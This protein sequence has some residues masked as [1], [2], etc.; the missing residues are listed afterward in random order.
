MCVSRSTVFSLSTPP[1]RQIFQVLPILFAQSRRH[2]KAQSSSNTTLHPTSPN[3]QIH[4]SVL[5]T[6]IKKGG[7]WG[8]SDQLSSVDDHEPD[9]AASVIQMLVASRPVITT[10]LTTKTHGHSTV[11]MAQAL[12]TVF[13]L[14]A[15]VRCL[16]FFFFLLLLERLPFLD[17]RYP[18]ILPSG[19]C[20]V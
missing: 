19:V 6:F 16:F 7:G 3:S 1:P 13:C 2:Y 17:S 18:S 14:P 10:S 20:P 11:T 15:P 4:C 12:T 9:V 8:C 5:N